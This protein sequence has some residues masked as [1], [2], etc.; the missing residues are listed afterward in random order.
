MT[1]AKQGDERV[2]IPAYEA[3]EPSP[4]HSDPDPGRTV[5]R[6]TF[7]DRTIDLGV[8]SWVTI[9]A[10]VAGFAAVA[11]RLTELDVWALSPS[12][13]RRAYDAFALYQGRSLEPGANLPETAPL[14]L[15]LQAFGFF[16]FGTTDAIARLMPA[17]VGVALVPLAWSLRP[18]VGR[19]A[20]LGMSILV[21][22]SPT[23]VYASRTGEPE[24]IVAGS[25]LAVLAALL[26]IG[27]PGHNPASVRRWCVLTGI[28]LGCL[29]ASG[30]AAIT[31]LLGLFIGTTVEAA[32][33]KSR[34]GAIRQTASAIRSIPGTLASIVSGLVATLLVLFTRMF[35]DISAIAGLGYTFADW[36]RLVTTDPGTA[37]TQF[38][39]LAALLYEPLAILFAVTAVYLAS[40]STATAAGGASGAA[41]HWPLFGGWFAP[42]FLL[43]SFSSGRTPEQAAHVALPLVLLG[44]MGMGRVL[45]RIDWREAL[46]GTGG[47]L[48]LT[49]LGLLIALA[50]VGI[51]ASRIDSAD[52]RGQAISQ[53]LFVAV[54]VLLPL[55]AAAYSLIRTEVRNSAG[56]QA[57]VLAILVV[58]VV[59]GAYGLRSTILLNYY[60]GDDGTELL[61]QRTATGAVRPLVD[62]LYRL[63]RDATLTRESVRDTTGG[64]SLNIALDEQLEWPFRWYFREFPNLDTYASGTAASANAE[65]VIAPTEEGMAEAGY[66][67]RNYPYLNRV[68]AAYNAPDAGDI[69]ADIVLPTHWIDGIKFLLYRDLAN[70][71]AAE[72]MTVA[73][74]AELAGRIAPN[75]GPFNLFDRAGPGN[76]RGKFSQPRGIAIDHSSGEVYVVDMGNLRVERFDAD[77]NFIGQWGAGEE[78]GAVEFGSVNGLGPTGIAIGPDGLVYVADTWNHR[79]VAI[80]NSGRVVREIGSGQQVDLGNEPT[81]IEQEP[82]SFF[83]PRAVTVYND[84]IYVVDTGNE[85]VLV[86]GLGGEFVRAFGGWGEVPGKLREPVGIAISEAGEVY[87]ADSDNARISVFTTSGFPVRQ[88]PV[89]AWV[90]GSYV[91]PYLAIGVDG[92]IYATSRITSSVEVFQ[93]DGTAVDSLRE[94]GGNAFQ[95][96]IGI[97][98]AADGSLLITDAER[99]AVFRY[100]PAQVIIDTSGVED[101]SGQATPA[102]SSDGTDG[103]GGSPADE[104]PQTGQITEPDDSDIGNESVQL[105]AGTPQSEGGA[106]PAPTSAAPPPPPP[107][108]DA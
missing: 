89:P 106:A 22:L 18:F 34:T 102:G 20:A 4:G 28:A 53:T 58:G 79:V 3:R 8:I 45:E 32:T 52:S 90:G 29:F 37:P 73:F 46:R 10:L 25:A 74:N 31:V 63:S 47:L 26:R 21:A 96:P 50:A 11:L 39:L 48:A 2:E 98:A 68:P 17:L 78:G 1:R 9:F 38:Y 104:Q 91:E 93:P 99:A 107:A 101:I 27:R 81:A 16:L 36:G 41:A 40:T 64:R 13:A 54:L 15:I 80:D 14:L 30:P 108:S 12:E 7:L 67:P 85:R 72:T 69:A 100:V 97:A 62:R 77:G 103:T 43:F 71:P 66:T 75:S 6:D 61:A 59:L 86:Y 49:Y 33:D 5:R 23:L 88:F 56:V 92:L 19:Y 51:L 95:Q 82:N 70:P 60:N 76:Q 94:V 87:I 65:V 105:P 57:G 35:S 24:I 42:V 83:G 55:L 84:E 44:G